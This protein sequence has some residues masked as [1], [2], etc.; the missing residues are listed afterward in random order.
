M[1]ESNISG[2]LILLVVAIVLLWFAVTDRLSR[3]LDAV[4]VIR[5]KSSVSQTNAS[6]TASA[7]GGAAGNVG[8]E[9]QLPSLPK[10]GQTNN[11]GISVS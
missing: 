3:V 6:P 11:V 1:G 5:G 9:L 2:S 8:V 10:L 7:I 4:D